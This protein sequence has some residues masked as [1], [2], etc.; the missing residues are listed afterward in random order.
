MFHKLANFIISVILLSVL[1]TVGCSAQQTEEQ[2]LASLRQMTRDGKLP[3]ENVVSDIES[4]FANKKTGA[5]AKL[6][7]ARIRFE[8]ND[9]AG[10]ASILNSNV[11]RQKTKVADEALWLR[12]KSWS[13]LA[14]TSNAS[15]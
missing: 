2:A 12:G 10:A 4:R 14:K 8:S 11:F 5:L 6:L 13:K 7:H 3:P 9:F 15:A 1:F